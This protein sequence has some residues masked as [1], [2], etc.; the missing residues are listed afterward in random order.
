MPPTK[1]KEVKVQSLVGFK[2]MEESGPAVS[3][4]DDPIGTSLNIRI[5]AGGLNN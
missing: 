1:I 2:K 5:A 4:D 3:T